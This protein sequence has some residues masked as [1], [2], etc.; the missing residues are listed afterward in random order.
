MQWLVMI[1]VLVCKSKFGQQQK[2]SVVTARRVL[3]FSPT[4]CTSLKDAEG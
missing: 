4:H 3:Q 1:L 2:N